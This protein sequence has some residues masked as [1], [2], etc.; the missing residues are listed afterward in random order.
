MRK[1][2]EPSVTETVLVL[3][4]GG[5][6]GAYECGVYK[7]LAK[8]GI[9]FD[10][11]AGSSIG[12]INSSII[13]SA[14]NAHKDTAQVLEDFWLT[15]AESDVPSPFLTYSLLP[16]A[17]LSST[18]LSADK[19]MAILSSMYSVMYG[20][21]KA[22]TPRWFK[23]DSLD[24]FSPYKWNYVYDTTHLK[25]TLN[26]YIDFRYLNK[27]DGDSEKNT[28]SKNN[29]NTNNDDLRS[30]LIITS[31][32][33][34]KGEPVIFDSY[35]MD[36]DADSIVACAGYP[37]YGIQWS[38]IDGRYLWDGSLLTNTPML[39]AI[40]ASPEHNKKFY[41]VDVFPREQKE[42]PTNMI[43]VWHRARDIIF[44]D[45]T[46]T[47]I[48]MLKIRERYLSLLKRIHT[49]INADDAKIDEKSKAKFKEIESEYN[50]LIHG[51]GAVIEEVTRVSRTEKTHYL[52]EDGD[53]SAYRIQK[54]IR[55]GEEDAE[56]A[57]SESSSQNRLKD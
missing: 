56:K 23:P 34:Q 51:Y 54:L 10:I 49:I 25:N 36:I 48:E 8:R 15:L 44:M 17:S 30:R 26:Q 22:F 52:Y 43:E 46:N 21:P 11:L 18:L 45:K 3:Q 55:Q 33:I 9:K 19:M 57:L 42:L 32:D 28:G 14:Q 20:N 13:C 2:E 5:S 39:E 53:F 40:K 12:A 16:L 7:T 1:Q 4:G 35:R 38:T 31:A 47:N 24:Y 41:I 6:L 27:I 29:N 37:F 50:E